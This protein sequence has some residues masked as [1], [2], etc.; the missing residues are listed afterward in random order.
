MSTAYNPEDSILIVDDNEANIQYLATLLDN[1]GYNVRAATSGE[2]AIS[3]VSRMLPDLILLDVM[4]P[5][6]DGYETLRKIK[7]ISAAEKIPVIFLTAKT[8]EADIIKGFE[9]GAVDY[10]K[11]P[12]NSMELLARIKTH[13]KLGQRDE[14]IERIARNQKYLL[15]LLT[16][17]LAGNLSGMDSMALWASQDSNRGAELSV[18]VRKAVSS[19]LELIQTVQQL[20]EVEI[21][22][23]LLSIAETSLGEAVKSAMSNLSESLQSKEIHVRQDLQYGDLVRAERVTLVNTVLKNILHNAVKFT[24]RG[25]TISITSKKVSDSA[26]LQITDSGEGFPDE[27]KGKIFNTEK[28]TGKAGTEQEPGTGFGLFITGKLIEAYGASIDIQ[29]APEGGTLVNL[30]FQ[31]P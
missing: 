19:S 24:P 1:E 9:E 29:S 23:G 31:I 30:Q 7:G 17:D 10:V 12:F 14:S 3:A 11:K 8:E 16:H 2:M 13:L 15:R 27:L 18:F 28:I 25:G 26:V 6:M 21:S 20:M 22:R 4:M 5:N